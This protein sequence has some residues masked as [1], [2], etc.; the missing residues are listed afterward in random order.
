MISL[1]L[2]IVSL[3]QQPQHFASISLKTYF[4]VLFQDNS[5]DGVLLKRTRKDDWNLTSSNLPGPVGIKA[6]SAHPPS[7]PDVPSD[8]E[9]SER[10]QSF[11]VLSGPNLLAHL[12]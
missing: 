10:S 4:T 9:P 6:L 3:A 12:T 5:L 2:R 11:F 8:L 1:E 7:L